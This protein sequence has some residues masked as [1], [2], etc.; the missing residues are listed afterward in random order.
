MVRGLAVAL[1]LVLAL[2]AAAQAAELRVDGGVLTYTAAPGKVSNLTFVETAPQRVEV[3]LIAGNTDAITATNCAGTGPYV[4][5][6]V[7]SALLEQ[8]GYRVVRVPRLQTRETE[9]GPG[10][11]PGQDV[12][13]CNVLPGLNR[14]RPSVHYAPLGVPRLDAAA[15]QAFRDA[16][17]QPVRVSR[18]P[19]IH[20]RTPFELPAR[21]LSSCPES[22]DRYPSASFTRRSLFRVLSSQF[23][24]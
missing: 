24:F 6:G 17:V 16:G 10:G 7:T 14:G 19:L 1:A 13:Y 23:V 5:D 8:L 21:R 4:C 22:T 9:T 11:L 12:V 2:P 20:R 15:E 18:T 3:T